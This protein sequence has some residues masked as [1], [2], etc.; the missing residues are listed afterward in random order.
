[1][2]YQIPQ[3]DTKGQAQ[4]RQPEG[5]AGA[6][7]PGGSGD[8]V[9]AYICDLRHGAEEVDVYQTVEAFDDGHFSCVVVIR[10]S[11]G[12]AQPRNQGR[13]QGP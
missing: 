13:G 5:G 6:C 11:V 8:G 12:H 7:E 10:F 3:H 9:G 4:G 1:M 2:L